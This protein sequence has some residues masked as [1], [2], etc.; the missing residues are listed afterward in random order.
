MALPLASGV[1]WLNPE[2]DAD[3]VMIGAQEPA[4]PEVTRIDLRAREAMID[5]DE[6]RHD[7]CGPGGSRPLALGAVAQISVPQELLKTRRIR[8]NVEIADDR[9]WTEV[10]ARQACQCREFCVANAGETRAE[11]P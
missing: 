3:G 11:R 9:E 4:D 8:R 1:G 2:L 5:L 7:E 6:E 10:L